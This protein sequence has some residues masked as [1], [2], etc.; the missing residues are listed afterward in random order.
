MGRNDSSREIA[1]SLWWQIPAPVF[2]SD[3][4]PLSH[5]KLTGKATTGK[6]LL[7]TMN[8]KHVSHAWIRLQWVDSLRQNL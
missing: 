3:W 8:N 4:Q 5:I 2:H 1:L 7:F 6:S